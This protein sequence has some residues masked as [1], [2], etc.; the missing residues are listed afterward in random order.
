VLILAGE[1]YLL[2]S[3]YAILR[4]KGGVEY[5]M[6][7]E[8]RQRNYYKPYDGI[9]NG[10]FGTPHTF[11]G[12]AGGYIAQPAVDNHDDRQDTYD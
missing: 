5:K 7:D 6:H 4:I 11:T 12:A 3:T 8:L 10:I 2:A 1:S 9:N